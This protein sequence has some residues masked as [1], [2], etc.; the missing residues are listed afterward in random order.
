MVMVF[1]GGCWIWDLYFYVFG[2]YIIYVVFFVKLM[3][4]I[5]LFFWFFRKENIKE[6]YN[7]FSL[8]CSSYLKKNSVFIRMFVLYCFIYY[9]IFCSFI[10]LKLY[11]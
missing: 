8:G 9:K 4:L 2:V 3:V 7:V 6:G 5:F 11:Y 1:R 10:V